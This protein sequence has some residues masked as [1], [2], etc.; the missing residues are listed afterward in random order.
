MAPNHT[1][2]LL[3][4]SARRGDLCPPGVIVGQHGRDGSSMLPTSHQKTRVGLQ[5][6]VNTRHF[7]AHHLKA[8]HQ[9]SVDI[10]SSQHA[11]E[12]PAHDSH[13][14]P[15][16]VPP[17]KGGPKMHSP[18]LSPPQKIEPSVVLG[19]CKA[20]V[21]GL[22]QLKA[23]KSHPPLFDSKSGQLPDVS[24]TLEA[25]GDE[26]NLNPEGDNLSV[27]TNMPPVPSLPGNAADA[28]PPAAAPIPGLN[29][30]APVKGQGSGQGHPFPC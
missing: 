26:V 29:H 28:G 21:L 15:S 20:E 16:Y 27:F 5:L 10:P 19:K 6:Q 2:T 14:P 25:D 18:S 23:T 24:G 12:Y 3:L 9:H 22:E 17:G 7:A 13:F 8:Y 11:N 30:K 4:P 1:V